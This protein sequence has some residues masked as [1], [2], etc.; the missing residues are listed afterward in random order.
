MAIQTL[1]T[2][3]ARIGKFKAD[4][5]KAAIPV[6]VLG[7][8]GMQKPIPKN[9][10][11]VATF[12][13]W[14]PLGGVDNQWITGANVDTYAS[15][16]ETAEGVTPTAVTL[17]AVDIDV[18][19]KQYAVLFS[20]TDQTMDFYEDDVAGEMKTQTGEAMGLIREMVRY[21]ELKGAT[22]VFY[23]GGTSR[24]TVDETLTLNLLRK[25][26]RSLMANH[27][28][29]IT[30]VISS[31]GNYGT[32]AVEAGFLVF[33]STDMESAIRDITGFTNVV[34]YGSKQPINENEIGSIER[35][36]FILSPELAGYINA[37]ALVGS[38]GLFST[39]GTNLDVYP[40]IVAAEDAWG[41]VALRGVN[42]IDPTF[43]PAGTK[44]KNDPLGQRGYIGAKAYHA[45]VIL[46]QGW[47]AVI[48]CGAPNLA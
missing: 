25:V 33:C 22:N 42:A 5:L 31:S 10:G 16:K 45:S 19:L 32:Q 3:A 34:D 39:G 30:K 48:E 38:T 18:T 20:I 14:L 8:T 36:R 4:I 21:G 17:T 41:Q 37:G 46:N 12:R 47:M 11:K 7:I 9:N 15:S 27:G 29:R 2:Q 6:E 24:V 23:S 26:T 43:L 40:V 1:A 35:Y 28:K 44:D 13:R